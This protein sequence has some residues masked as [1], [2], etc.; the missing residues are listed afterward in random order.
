MKI[1]AL[2]AL[3]ALPLLALVPQEASAQYRCCGEQ[4][5]SEPAP[6]RVYRVHTT[7]VIFDRNEWEAETDIRIKRDAVVH[8]QCRVGWCRILSGQFR[9]AFVLERCLEPFYSNYS[10][11]DYDGYRDGGYRRPYTTYKRVYDSGDDRRYDS[12]YDRPSY[13][14]P[15]YPRYRK[16]YPGYDD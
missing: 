5:Y 8:A 6:V 10:E 1:Y 9:N 7:A 14:R 16:P 2:A 15:S 4:P 13:D 11:Y 12:S 3:L